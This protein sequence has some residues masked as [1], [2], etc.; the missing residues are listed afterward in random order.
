MAD[1]SRAELSTIIQ[2]EYSN[3]LLESAASNSVA[4]Q[5]F[6]QVNM[7][8]KV[9]NLPV[10]ATLPEADF[11]GESATE[12]GGVKPTS[13]VTWSNKVLTAEE[14]AVIIPIHENAVDDAT[15][16]VLDAITA[17]AG[18]AIGR[19]LDA[20][21]MFGVDKPAAWTSDDLLA[22][23]VAAA[24][25][26]TVSAT[27]GEDDLAGAILQAAQM[28]DEAGW[29]PSAFAGPRGLRYR[30]ANLRADDGQ[31]VYRGPLAN[32]ADDGGQVVGL[33][34]AWVSG[35][36]WDRDEA[37]AF[38]L[39]RE[40]VILGVRQ[41]I[42][43]KFLDQ[44]TVGG[45]NLAERDMVALRF[46]ARYAYVLGDNTNAESNSVNAPVAAVLPAGS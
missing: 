36:V 2:D 37:E 46:K 13:Q 18:A 22:A 6:R 15:V 44:A 34:A 26:V 39:D 45:I 42:T 28:V 14:I 12:S 20:A 7:G 32:G 17:E 25:T 38:V 41:D 10:L 21:V 8:T 11:V 43:V 23:A 9:Q 1:I 3:V 16:D 27:P 31:P 19:K 4:L 40:R 24:Q 5:V 30:L 35:R 29:E 33:D